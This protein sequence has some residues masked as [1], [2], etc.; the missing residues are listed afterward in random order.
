MSTTVLPRAAAAFPAVRRARLDPLLLAVL[1]LAAGLC[2]WELTSSGYS[3]SY[4]AAA[5]RAGS[6]SWT[7]WFF[8]S[9]DPGSFI[10]VDKPPLS[11]WLMGL[12]ARVLGFSSFSILLPQ[13]LCTIA[14]V[15]LL[16]ATVRRLFGR[17]AG[18]LAAAALAITPIT[19]AIARVNNPDALLVL[20]MV[21][22]GYVLVR[23][24]ESGRTRH[25]LLCGALVGLAFMTKML[26]GWMIVPALA[27]AYALAG[28]PRLAVR[29]AQLAAAGAATVA[30]SAAWPLAVTFWPGDKPFIGGSEDGGVWDLILGYNGFGRIFGEGGPGGGASFGGAA[31]PLAHAQRAGRRPGRLAAAARA[32][33][34]RGRPLAHARRVAHRPAARRLGAVRR[35]GA[36][37]HR[38]LLERPGH[39]PP[40]LRERARARRRGARRRRASWRSGA[41]RGRPGPAS[42][43]SMPRCSGRPGWRSR[44][45]RAR[46]TSHRG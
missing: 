10:T 45:W 18:L 35:L 9:L 17:T 16:Y 25:L 3:N 22:A 1:A 43:R 6:E 14:A 28:P 4:Y 29:L 7:A 13:A 34:S 23:A 36:G 31:R 30:V 24:L 20:L 44:C 40:V 42:P 2:L 27:A 37:A 8:G 26:Q 5:A 19:V 38:R 21:A 15:A 41:G 33:R 39:L 32:R 46:P 12:S 11:L